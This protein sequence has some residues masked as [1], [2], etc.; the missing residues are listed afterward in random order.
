[1]KITSESKNLI[2]HIF[3]TY[4][5]QQYKRIS[6]HKEKEENADPNSE[7]R[8]FHYR[9]GI[10]IVKENEEVYALHYELTGKRL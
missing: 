4:L 10:D 5:L 3:K 9:A 1:M 7:K 2:T 6:Y 8:N